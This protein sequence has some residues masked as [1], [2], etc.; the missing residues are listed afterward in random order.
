MSAK[1]MLVI[2][3]FYRDTKGA[4][5][6][7]VSMQDLEGNS[8]WKSTEVGTP[9]STAAWARRVAPPSRCDT[10]ASLRPNRTAPPRSHTGCG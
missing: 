8:N 2:R 3:G 5:I 1:D 9:S 10:M 7:D 4:Q 6:K